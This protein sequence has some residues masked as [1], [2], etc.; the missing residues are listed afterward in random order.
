MQT[1]LVVLIV[2]VALGFTGWKAW[3]MFKPGPK[4]AGCGCSG[5]AKGCAGCPVMDLKKR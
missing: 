2:A 3:Q 1:L 5:A 4:A